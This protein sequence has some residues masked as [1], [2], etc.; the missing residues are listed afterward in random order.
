[1][2][3]WFKNTKVLLHLPH[4]VTSRRHAVTSFD[5]TTW[6][7]DVMWRHDITPYM[8][9]LDI[10]SLNQKILKM[11][12]FWL[13]DLDLW[14]ITLTF[15]LVRDII[16]VNPCT[17]FRGHTM[18]GSA[19]RALTDRHTHRHTDTHTDGSVFI[20]SAADAGGNEPILLRLL[21]Q[22]T[23]SDRGLQAGR[24]RWYYPELCGGLPLWNS[25]TSLDWWQAPTG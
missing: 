5:V 23:G 20:T 18:N 12:C 3:V 15:A 6:S 24:Y 25:E 10:C 4:Y 9:R 2:N 11:T 8:L 7:H 14:P 1:M 17:K 13:C 21:A 19:V 22:I 16:K